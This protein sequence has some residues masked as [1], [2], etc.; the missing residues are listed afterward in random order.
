M[1]LRVLFEACKK[2]LLSLSDA[3]LSAAKSA[4]ES[5]G[6]DVVLTGTSANGA[7]AQAKLAEARCKPG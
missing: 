3:L 6:K 7:S 2:N 4:V 1:F 5:S